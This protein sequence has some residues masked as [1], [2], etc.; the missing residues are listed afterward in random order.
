MPNFLFNQAAKI[1]HS[2]EAKLVARRWRQLQNMGMRIGKNV[3]MP[4]ST[5]IDVPHC[6]LISIGDNCVFGDNCA[7]LAH[8]AMPNGFIDATKIGLVEIYEHCHFGFGT[9][10][11]PGV[12]IG[13]RVVIAANS[14]VAT[15][16]PK[17]SVARGTPAKVI[18]ALDDYLEYHR[19]AM[20]KSPCF[21]YKKYSIEFLTASRK[22]EM[23]EKLKSFPGYITGGY[24]SQ[25]E[26]GEFI[27]GDH[28][29]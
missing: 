28:Q 12:K 13:P 10:I 4:Q 18:G 29:D 14:V 17:N 11:M 16:I 5:W 27:S 24:T 2:I 8:D 26:S 20:Q 7:I 1:S 9:I 23:I 22:R 25:L 6:F 3:Y 19:L 15:D 21:P